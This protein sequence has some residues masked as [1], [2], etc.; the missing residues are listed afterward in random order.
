MMDRGLWEGLMYTIIASSSPRFSYGSVGA[1]MHDIFEIVLRLY[2]VGAG[3][4]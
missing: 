3:G 1:L 2:V 4:N